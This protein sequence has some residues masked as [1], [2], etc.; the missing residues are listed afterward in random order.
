LRD[1]EKREWAERLTLDWMVFAALVVE[2]GEHGG[3]PPEVAR[4][5][6]APNEQ[7]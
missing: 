5:R 2:H 7:S 4:A 1:E 6:V 3:G